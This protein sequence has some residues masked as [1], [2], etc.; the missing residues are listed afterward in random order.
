VALGNRQLTTL[1]R[2]AEALLPA[3][4]ALAPGAADTDVAGR[5][6]SFVG[7]LP[8]WNARFIGAMLVAWELSSLLSSY[9]R[10]FGQLSPAER[11]SYL[12]ACLRARRGLR[13]ALALWLKSLCLMA[14]CS[15][16]RVEEA[17]GFTGSCLDK[18]PAQ[19]GPRLE[20]VVYP[21]I[22]GRVEERADVCVVGSGAGGAVVAKELA[23]GGL[24]VIVLEEGAYFSRP[25]FQGSPWER[26]QRLYRNGGLTAAFG[27]SVVPIP[28][29]KCVGGTTVVNSG[30]CFRTPE[31][32]LRRWEATGIEGL[33]PQSMEPIFQRVEEELSVQP[34]PR[35]IIGRNALVFERGV[36]ALGLHGRPIQRAIR[37][38]RGCG[39]CTFGCP[40]DA[41][42]SMHVSYLPRAAARGARVFAGCRVDRILVEGGRAIGVEAD[43]LD[44]ATEQARGRL[45]VSA[46]VVVLAAGA[47]HSPALLMRNGL[48]N[49]PVGR[50]L[51]I[52]PATGVGA[53]F[54]EDVF[55]W[56]GTLQSYYVDD[57]HESLG[58]LLEVTSPLPGVS[59]ASL[60]GTGLELKQALG[61]YKRL[62]SVGL[63]VSDSA[64]GRVVGNRWWREPLAFY[65]LSRKDAARLQKGIA[66]AAEVFLEA[67]ARTVHTGL[68]RLPAVAGRRDLERLR[69]AAVRPEEL[70]V[71]GFH[72]M[73]SCR[74][75]RDPATSVVGPYG[76]IHAVRN[77]FLAD[78]SVL[79]SCAGVN[80]QVTI[81]ALAT[82]TAFHLLED[83]GRYFG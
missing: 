50:N 27:R 82:R 28:L 48:T 5:L 19:D 26:M 56:R 68:A 59:A 6:A 41:K 38:C 23:E 67:G 66:L 74:M 55:G 37:G 72:P 12:D 57:L 1:R 51:S 29:G 53:L 54:D 13:R 32:V 33:D 40:S 71:V 70:T 31:S 58:V 39:V 46:R 80:P 20:P 64:T 25:D 36:E 16:P 30:T 43:I 42:Q 77:L 21:H 65:S 11:Q 44:P 62:A 83:G 49:G 7:G 10:P 35:E 60:P 76:E 45:R 14:Y 52:H 78:A 34:V 22:R 18:D 81:M 4:G 15:H 47:I 73:G 63:F 61:D 9:R 17:I 8:R 69:N 24:S 2:T 3:G 75:G 79:P